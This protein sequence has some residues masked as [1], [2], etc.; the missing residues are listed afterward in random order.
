MGPKV[1]ASDGILRRVCEEEHG[2]QGRRRSASELWI[3]CSQ[4]IRDSGVLG[5]RV[6]LL[7]FSLQCLICILICIHTSLSSNYLKG[8]SVGLCRIFVEAK[9]CG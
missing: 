5:I 9:I 8:K 1:L 6:H 7:N 2:G 4:G 3:S